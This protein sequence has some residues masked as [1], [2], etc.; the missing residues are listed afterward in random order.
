MLG[1]FFPFLIVLQ[2]GQKVSSKDLDIS[3]MY[4][5]IR[6]CWIKP[7]PHNGWGKDPMEHYIEPADDI[8]R[9]RHYRNLICH[10]DASEMDINAFN[11]SCLDLFGV[12]Y[13]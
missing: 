7:E 10:S 9:I 13:T 6:N 12:I 4:S 11:S 3:L 8:E 2:K 5:L 1:S